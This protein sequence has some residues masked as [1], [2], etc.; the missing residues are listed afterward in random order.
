[1]GHFGPWTDI[2]C[3]NDEVSTDGTSADPRNVTRKG[4]Q[5]P[6]RSHAA[7][8]LCDFAPH[9]TQRGILIG[10]VSIRKLGTFWHQAGIDM[11]HVGGRFWV[12]LGQF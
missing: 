6:P 7:S 12:I 5:I 2:Y 8:C 11:R 4:R 10:L 1:M 9:L 3:Q